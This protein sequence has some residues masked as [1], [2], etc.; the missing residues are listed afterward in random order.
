M[1]SKRPRNVIDLTDDTESIRPKSKQPRTVA[2]SS[3][4][5]T[6]S[7]AARS[8]QSSRAA[9]RVGA[10]QQSQR[11]AYQQRDPY[12]DDDDEYGLLDLTQADDGPV[13]GLYGTIDNKIVGVRHYSGI[14]SPSEVVVLKRDPTN[15]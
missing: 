15:P 4:T 6:G 9:S 11:L 5:Y 10:P 12:D 2:S 13:F 14:V 7:S 8:S 1:S 3:Q